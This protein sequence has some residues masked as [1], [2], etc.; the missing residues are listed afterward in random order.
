MLLPKR[1]FFLIFLLGNI[2]QFVLGQNYP[3]MSQKDHSKTTLEKMI[4]TPIGYKRIA[5]RKNSFAEWVRNLPMQEKDHP[6]YLYNGQKKANQE[7]H[8]AVLAIDTGKQDLQQCADFV[9]RLFAEYFFALGQ[10]DKIY[11][12]HSSA[13]EPIE[14]IRWAKGERPYFKKNRLFW[15]PQTKQ[16]YSYSNFRNYL[17]FVFSYAGTY[18]LSLEMVKVD[19]KDIKIGDVFIQG[20]FPGHAVIVLDKA[21]HTQTGEIIFLLGQSYMPAQEPHILKN[22]EREDLN[23]WYTIPSGEKIITPEWV[24][25]KNQLKRFKQLQN[26]E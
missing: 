22:P 10:Y 7:A 15:K 14:Y 1:L 6:V 23:P 24:F 26:A 20:G 4:P 11:F 17:N 25:E 18:S 12:N 16:D 8:F 13:K 9:M 5:V 2:F 3:W 19:I 21:T